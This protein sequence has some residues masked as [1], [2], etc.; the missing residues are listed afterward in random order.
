MAI[1]KQK[2]EEVVAKV[3]GIIA[4]ASTL[5]FARFKGLTVEEQNVVRRAL[6][7]QG[8]GYMVAKKTLVRRALDA[9][10]FTGDVPVLDGEVALAY[11]ADELAPARELAVFVKQFSEHLAWAGGVFGGTYVSVQEIQSIAAI[12]GLQEL[13]ARLVQIINSPLRAFVVVLGERAKQQ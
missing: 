9:A 6:R 10:K 3:S 8:V 1:N 2:K 5:V 7:A 4:G 13:K 11:G 12:P